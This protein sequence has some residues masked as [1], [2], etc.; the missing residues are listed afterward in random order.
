MR[1]PENTSALNGMGTQEGNH[2]SK[3]TTMNPQQD[4]PINTTSY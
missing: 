3:Q 4:Q 2:K 1:E